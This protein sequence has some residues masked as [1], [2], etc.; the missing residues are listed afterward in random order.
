MP[1]SKVTKPHADQPIAPSMSTDWAMS[2][3]TPKHQVPLGPFT[4]LRVGGPARRLIEVR[5]EEHLV[6]VVRALDAA[7]ERLLLLA[8]G[9][10]VLIADEGFAGTVVLIR[11]RGMTVDR[12]ANRVMVTLQAGEP[13]DAF[14]Q[15][16][17]SQ[18]WVGI[19]ALSGIPGRAG[20][21]PIQNV[22]A[23]G[24]EVSQ[25]IARVRTYDR[26]QRKIVD[27]SADQCAFGY[28]ASRFKAAPRRHVVLSVTFELDIGDQSRAVAYAELARALGVE[29]GGR[30]PLGAVREAVLALRRSKGMLLD[31]EDHDTWSAG[32]FFTNPLLS[33]QQA[34]ELPEDAPRYVQADGRVKTSAAWLIAQAGFDKGAGARV[35]TGTARLSSKHTLA[36]TN[37]GEATA[38]DLLN[39]A[40]HVQAQVHRRFGI[41]LTSEPVLVGCSL[42]E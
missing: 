41:S 30:A 21:T 10:N 39:L 28:R 11:T 33:A 2:A 5:Q 17:V 20:A 19:E 24:Q 8:D 34:A 16:A 4:T 38:Q 15:H 35:G 40:N 13:W 1:T 14:V 7:G 31:A 9:S 3:I 42:K 29:L 37:R 27:Y 32:S 26:M 36:I 18:R 23:Y 22:G 6:D 12:Q 25:T